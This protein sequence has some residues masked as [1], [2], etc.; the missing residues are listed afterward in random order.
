[1][2]VSIKGSPSLRIAVPPSRGPLLQTVY[3][4]HCYMPDSLPV[5]QRRSF[6]MCHGR[7][8]LL[9]CIHIK[10]VSH[11]LR[12]PPVSYLPPDS[13]APQDSFMQMSHHQYHHPPYVTELT[14]HLKGMNI[15]YDHAAGAPSVLTPDYAEPYTL[16]RGQSSRFHHSSGDPSHWPPTDSRGWRSYNQPHSPAHQEI[17]YRGPKPH[18]PHFTADDPCQFARLKIVLDNILPA[19]ATE[20]FKYQ[21]LVD[22]LKLE[23][24]LLIADSYSNSMY[25]YSNTMASLTELYGQPHKLALQRINEV[26]TEPAVKSGYGRGFRL[27][28]LKVRALVG[29]LDQLG[30]EG[31]TELECRSHISRLLSKLPHDLR[32]QFKRFINPIR[33]PVPN[34]LDFS[35]WLEYEVRI[36]DDDVQRY[37]SRPFKVCVLTTREVSRS[38]RSL[39]LIP[40]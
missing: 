11:F 13:S 23:D 35:D 31:R 26:M 16:P 12:P 30:K 2:M 28:A 22:H 32:A 25:P 1:M 33:T 40:P 37:S 7:T 36:Q 10:L 8:H 9:H 17:T 38:N 39:Q 21:I 15:N 19:D 18:I 27:F 5:D 4:L 14:D 24:A 20:R 6:G 34:L 29:M 3:Q